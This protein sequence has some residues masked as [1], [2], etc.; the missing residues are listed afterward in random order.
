MTTPKPEQQRKPDPAHPDQFP[1]S[2]F[3][4]NVPDGPTTNVTGYVTAPDARGGCRYTLYEAYLN[5]RTLFPNG[6]PKDACR[7]FCT[8]GTIAAFN[9][10]QGSEQFNSIDYNC[11]KAN[12]MCGLLTIDAFTAPPMMC[13][14]VESHGEKHMADCMAF[15]GPGEDGT[16]AMEITPSLIAHWKASSPP[17]KPYYPVAPFY[18]A[19]AEF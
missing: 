3:A 15:R 4:P 16:P 1:G 9:L 17:G 8:Y 13:D 10:Q 5:D 14:T 12:F 6:P 19:T 7:K 2:T 11:G 18:T